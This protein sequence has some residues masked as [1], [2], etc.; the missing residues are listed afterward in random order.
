M[1]NLKSPEKKYYFKVIFNIVMYV[2]L[3]TAIAVI[4]V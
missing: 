3:T 4:L 2:A 1:L